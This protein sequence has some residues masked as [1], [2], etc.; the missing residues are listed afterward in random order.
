MEILSHQP[1]DCGSL[2]YWYHKE[3]CFFTLSSKTLCTTHCKHQMQQAFL[4]LNNRKTVASRYGDLVSPST[5]QWE[6]GISISRMDVNHFS[7]QIYWQTSEK[8]MNCYYLVNRHRVNDSQTYY[9]DSDTTWQGNACPGKLLSREQSVQCCLTIHFFKQVRQSLLTEFCE[10][11]KDTGMVR[12]PW[13]KAIGRVTAPCDPAVLVPGKVG[14]MTWIICSAPT[15]LL[16]VS[17]TTTWCCCCC[18][19][20]RPLRGDVADEDFLVVLSDAMQPLWALTTGGPR[21]QVEHLK[22]QKRYS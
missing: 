6:S 15:L 17:I 22:P 8:N 18:C 5:R 21:L 4:M 9:T 20:C 2:E 10:V 19:C 13:A 7:S 16:P 11:V 1:Q 12:P 3:Y 14:L